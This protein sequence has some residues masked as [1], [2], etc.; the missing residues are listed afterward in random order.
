MSD[1]DPFQYPLSDRVGCNRFDLWL[2]DDGPASFSILSRIEWAVTP[3]GLIH[4]YRDIG[5]QY[6]LSDRVGCN[7]RRRPQ[8]W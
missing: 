7:A 2:H 1:P 4:G 3:Q 6:P 8:S 5:F